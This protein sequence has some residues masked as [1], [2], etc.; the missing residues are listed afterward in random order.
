MQSNFPQEPDDN[1]PKKTKSF[2]LSDAEIKKKAGIPEFV[3]REDGKKFPTTFQLTQDE[4][5]QFFQLM[6]PAMDFVNEKG[7]PFCAF[8]QFANSPSEALYA[9]DA[10][11]PGARCGDTA[12]YM[13]KIGA[14]VFGKEKHFRSSDVRKLY[15][16][17]LM[18]RDGFGPNQDGDKKNG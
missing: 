7:L 16:M 14:I 6:K 4:I 3:T 2:E 15:H 11:M 9:F 18:M 12:Y 1:E 5:E 10:L 8:A 17:A 13:A